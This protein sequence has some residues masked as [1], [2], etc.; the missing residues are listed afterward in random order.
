MTSDFVSPPDPGSPRARARGSARARRRSV[1]SLLGGCCIVSAKTRSSSPASLVWVFMFIVPSAPDHRHRARVAREA[2]LD[3]Q[4]LPWARVLV[5]G[6]AERVL[7]R[8]ARGSRGPSRRAARRRCSA[9]PG[10]ARG[11]SS[12]LAQ[13]SLA[14]AVEVP[15]TPSSRAAGPFTMTHTATGLVVACMPCRLN[16]GA[17]TASTAAISG[18]QVL[19]VASS[20]DGIDGD[21]LDRRC[22]E[23]RR[24][25]RHDALAA[26]RRVPA[27]MRCTR[28]TVG[29]TIGR[30]SL[31][32]RSR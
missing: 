20:Q 25:A 5:L 6:A 7:A 12:A 27:S 2:A 1:Y 8:L 13:R 31:H 18:R 11:R 17:A 30:P 14:E 22:A 15:L 24:D 26:A 16:S 21:A 23:A 28:S 10:A 19:G 9:G 3:V 29:G 4:R 32:R